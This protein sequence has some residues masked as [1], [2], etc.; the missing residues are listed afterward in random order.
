[1]RYYTH[2][3]TSVVAGITLLETTGGHLALSTLAGI[4]IGSLLPDIDE[5][6]SYVGHRSLG[7]ARVVKG[8][9]GHRGFTHSILAFLIVLIPFYFLGHAH[10]HSVT[11][12]FIL[13]YQDIMDSTSG[14]ISALFSFL[15]G[16]AMGYGFHILED[17]CSVSG[18][19]L[20]YPINKKIAIPIYRTGGIREKIIFATS[21]FYLIYLAKDMMLF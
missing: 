13:K 9:F 5:P 19:P 10:F 3:A 4:M 14:W 1:M 12:D 2:V 8:I 21:I 7:A 20:L 16:I 11:P 15:Y 17:M 18:V 6:N